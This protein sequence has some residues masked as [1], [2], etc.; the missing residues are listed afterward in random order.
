MRVLDFGNFGK[1]EIHGVVALEPIV[2]DGSYAP[3]L[4][5]EYA[6]LNDGKYAP[7]SSFK[8]GL[9]DAGWKFDNFCIRRV[10]NGWGDGYGWYFGSDLESALEDYFRA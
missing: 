10:D 5:P 6:K 7:G 1:L 3:N 2:N 4:A 8:G 9:Q